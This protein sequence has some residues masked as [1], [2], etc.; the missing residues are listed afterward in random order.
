MKIKIKYDKGENWEFVFI[1]RDKGVKGM[2]VF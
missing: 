1:Q 2:S